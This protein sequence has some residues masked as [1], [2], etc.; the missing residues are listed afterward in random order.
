VLGFVLE[1][2]PHS[3]QALPD[4]HLPKRVIA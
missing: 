4:L 2:K 1:R 3:D